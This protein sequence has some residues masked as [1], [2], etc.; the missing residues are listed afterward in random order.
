MRTSAL[1]FFEF[2]CIVSEKNGKLVWKPS[3]SLGIL[4]IYIGLESLRQGIDLN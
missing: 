3:R 1:S 4:R 2:I